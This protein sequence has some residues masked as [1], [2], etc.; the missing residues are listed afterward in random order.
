[1]AVFS[2]VLQCVAV[3]CSVAMC[4]S[5]VVAGESVC[6]SVSLSLSLD[7][8]EYNKS[9]RKTRASVTIY[10]ATLSLSRSLSL[11]FSLSISFSF[12]LFLSLR[13]SLSV[14][15]SR[16][17]HH[18]RKQKSR[19]LLQTC[20]EKETCIYCIFVICV[21]LSLSLFRFRLSFC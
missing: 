17:L 6:L 5:V 12:S 2:S 8:R 15:P 4:R 20:F 13:L 11:S 14:A 10:K 21:Y 3:C 1:M 19:A 9:A 18:T 16:P 7:T